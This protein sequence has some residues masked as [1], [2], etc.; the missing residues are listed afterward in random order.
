MESSREQ[1]R[2]WRRRPRLRLEDAEAIRAQLTVPALVAV[3]SMSSGL[4]KSERA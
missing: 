3:E 4:A 1:W 2:E